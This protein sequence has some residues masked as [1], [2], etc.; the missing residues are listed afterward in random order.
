MEIAIRPLDGRDVAEADRIFRVAFGTFLGL[1]EPASFMGDADLV[2]T[3]WWA[4][5]SAAFG[6][7]LVTNSSVRTSSLTG[8]ASASSGR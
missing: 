3:R 2:G 5:P 4:T 7:T 8:A 1:P 6:A